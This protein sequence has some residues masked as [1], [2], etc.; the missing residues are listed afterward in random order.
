MVYMECGWTIP[1]ALADFCLCLVRLLSDG[2]DFVCI[3]DPDDPY[4]KVTVKLAYM[5]T[6]LYFHFGRIAR[7]VP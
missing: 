7:A 1:M 6:A 2:R 5:N 3:L 4:G